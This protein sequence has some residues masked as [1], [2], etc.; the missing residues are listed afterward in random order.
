M[1]QLT[2]LKTDPTDA[3]ELQ[4]IYMEEFLLLQKGRVG[5]L[6]PFHTR[7]LW[8]DQG[9][10]WSS[11]HSHFLSLLIDFHH[12]PYAF[13]CIYVPSGH[14]ADQRTFRADT[15]RQ[16]NLHHHKLAAQSPSLHQL[17][18]GDWNGHVG[19]DHN[20]SDPRPIWALKTA[21][22]PSGIEQRQWLATTDLICIDQ[23]YHIGRRGTWIHPGTKQWYELDYFC[24]SP[25]ILKQ[26]QTL[27]TLCLGFS[28]HSAKQIL[29]HLPNPNSKTAKRAAKAKRI[30]E[31][32]APS[33]S[34]VHFELLRGA[35][36]EAQYNRGLF[37]RTI[38]EKLVQE[39]QANQWS[40]PTPSSGSQPSVMC[41]LTIYTDGSSNGQAQHRGPRR[42]AGWGFT[43]TADH[44]QWEDYFG[45]VIFSK[46]NS[47][48]LGATVASNNS[49]ELSAI[50]Q[51]MKF[52]LL[53][54]NDSTPVK[55]KY[56][57]VYAYKMATSQWSPTS[58][59]LLIKNVQQ[60][61]QAV[62]RYRPII[63]EHVF[64]HTGVPGND[65]ADNLAKKGATGAQQLWTSF[66]RTRNTWEA[67]APRPLKVGPAP[68]R[69]E[70]G[71]LLSF[72]TGIWA[73]REWH[74]MCWNPTSRGDAW[75]L[76]PYQ[77]GCIFRWYSS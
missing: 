63:W 19:R 41:N 11:N 72:C 49:A 62:N 15:Y 59:T 1:V 29:F 4:M 52:L 8:L 44:T 54:K 27:R 45:P 26:T 13:T 67:A 24:A 55:I 73:G 56:D 71:A 33:N 76:V 34:R 37:Q 7:K 69:G 57:S 75:S 10:R 61:V 66:R 21:T 6:L 3:H 18:G 20:L 16:A 32:Q 14:S 12:V 9:A 28:D 77:G 5:F 58:N 60:L 50:G 31:V 36:P 30:A 38:H 22:S 2:E 23:Y 42:A 40:L 47:N 17:W 74:L 51:A 35:S 65:R 43:V 64:G 48:Y 70:R 68:P 46:T 39:F 25:G 53:S